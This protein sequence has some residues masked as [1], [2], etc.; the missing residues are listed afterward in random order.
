MSR[1]RTSVFNMTRI[2]QQCAAD[3]VEA[4]LI[5]NIG[6]QFDELWPGTQRPPDALIDLSTA[7]C[8]LIDWNS[9][10][11]RSRSIMRKRILQL[12]ASLTHEPEWGPNNLATNAHAQKVVPGLV[13]SM[14]EDEQTA[15]EPAAGA[16]LA[17]LV[18]QWLA[19]GAD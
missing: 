5:E 9:R 4:L 13:A 7:I 12:I 15:L 6:R 11:D 17:D 16:M 10:T 1:E 3:D 19:G 8:A 14:R 18:D 2:A